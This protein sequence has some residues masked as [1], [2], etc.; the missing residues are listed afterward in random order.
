MSKGLLVTYGG[1]PYTPSSLFPDNGMAN[2]AATLLA[3]GH[4]VRVWDLNTVSTL[5]RMMPPS[6]RPKMRELQRRLPDVGRDAETTAWARA[7]DAEVER[8]FAAVGD[9]LGE[10]VVREVEAGGYDWV[11]F[12]LYMGDG[13]RT[14]VRIA[15]RLKARLPRV[16]VFAGG[17]QLDLVRGAML[18]RVAA[19]DAVAVAEGEQT[20]VPLAEYAEGK[21]ALADVPN[22]Y[23]RDGASIR[24]NRL[25]RVDEMD[26]L[27][28]PAYDPHVYPALAAPDEKIRVLTYDE[29][30]G[31]PYQCAFCIH[32]TKS[33]VVRRT[34]SAEMVADE[35]ETLRRRYDTRLF[36]FAG[37]ATPYSLLADMSEL[38]IA[39]GIDLHYSIY[40]TPHGLDPRQLPLLVE[41]GLWGIFFGVESG[42]AR[43]LREGLGKRKNRLPQVE[44]ALTACL[45]AGLFT[46]GSVIYP[47][48]GEDA[49]STEETV[50]L[51]T[52]VFAGRRNG[53]VPVQFAGLFPETPWFEDR[54]R[55]GFEIANE[56]DY[57][58]EVMDYRIKSLM[59]F[60]LWPE[61]S[62]TLDGKPQRELA[63]QSATF[64]ARLRGAGVITMLLDDTAL[65]ATLAGIPMEEAL[66]RL[67][68]MFLTGDE[69][70]I[71][72][73]VRTVNGRA[74]VDGGPLPRPVSTAPDVAAA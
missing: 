47:A 63:R 28:T 24:R 36:R 21:R 17:P 66:D 22:I 53:S 10:E 52:R 26:D 43:V 68:G 8:N 29:S 49:E 38:L 7:L 61:A 58:H 55:Y 9:A 5:A 60:A 50:A 41:G 37:S 62:Y 70:A 18:E 19:F 12:K 44:A 32:A 30:R 54:A 72:D 14:S 1:F 45:D 64:M 56:N 2:M 15:E 4:A 13:F 48:P 57:L 46:V 23:W 34:K 33:G 51:L 67:V 39:R 74:R 69:A 65:I 35:L 71:R 73:L 11:G 59:P 16:K 40:A 27:P 42:S 3:A 25:S 6:L 20:I 31:C